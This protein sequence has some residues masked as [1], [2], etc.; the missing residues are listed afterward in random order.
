MQDIEFRQ[1]IEFHMVSHPIVVV[2]QPHFFPWLGY[3][4]KLA[5]A[6]IFIIQDNV[7]FRRRYFQ[8]RTLVRSPQGD[9]QWLTIPVQA[10]RSTLIR[11][12]TVATSTWTK[13]ILKTLKHSYGRFPYFNRYWDDICGSLRDGDKYLVDVNQITTE[14]IFKLLGLSSA[15]ERASSVNANGTR[16]E[17]VI[18]ICK[19]F[20]AQGYIYGE[21]GERLCHPKKDFLRNNIYVYQQ[22][23][24][25]NFDKCITNLRPTVPTVPNI[26]ILEFLFK[27]G[28]TKTR[29]IIKNCW[30]LEDRARDEK[31]Q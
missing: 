3:Y 30:K 28:V 26:S 4:N 19:H 21:G 16:R 7:Q 10:S 31:N 8:N 2:H 5:N 11:D 22:D 20:N 17:R 18:T 14:I 25:I 24:R 9:P 12:V 29:D 23:F 27:Y 1:E 6:D 15:I 13:N